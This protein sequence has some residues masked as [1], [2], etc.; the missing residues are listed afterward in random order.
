MMLHDERLSPPTVMAALGVF[1]A[2]VFNMKKR[3]YKGKLFLARVT[4]ASAMH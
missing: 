4:A 1:Y 2:Q 3:I